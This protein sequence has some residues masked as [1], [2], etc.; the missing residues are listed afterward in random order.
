MQIAGADLIQALGLVAMAVDLYGSTLKN[1]VRLK[2]TLI[3]SGILFGIHFSLLSAWTG[4]ASEFLTIL[5]TLTSIFYKDVRA[6]LIFMAAYLVAG[7][8]TCQNATDALPY[9]ASLF[10]TYGMFSLTGVRMRLVFVVGQS[11]WLAY[12]ILHQS[13]GA[14]LLYAILI[15]S[16]LFTAWRI[17]KVGSTREQNKP[18]SSVPNGATVD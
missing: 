15:P 9:L 8:T 5:R 7:F 16:T 3:I 4:A 2:V 1:D 14:S 6:M 17:M 12:S 11:C 10:A 13:I 18:C